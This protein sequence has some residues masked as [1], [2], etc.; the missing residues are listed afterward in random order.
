MGGLTQGFLVLRIW[1]HCYAFSEA[2]GGSNRL[3]LARFSKN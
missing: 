2:L 1:F 3:E